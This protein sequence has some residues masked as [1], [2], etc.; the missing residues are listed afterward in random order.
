MSSILA[1]D[2]GTTGSTALVIGQDGS[3]L[4]RGYREF[5][6]HFPQPGWVE[7]D[8]EEIFRVSVEAM[9]DAV[10]GSGERPVG[11]GITNQRETVVLWDRRTLAPVAPAIVWQDRRTTDRCREIREAG[12][13]PMLRERT[14]LVAD[15]YFSATKLEWL[16]RDPGL[17]KRAAKGELAAGTV[18]SWL[19]AKLTGGSSHVTDHTNA[20]RTLLYDLRSRDWAPELLEQ[21]GV[22][23]EVLPAIVRS[24]GVVGETDPR[25]LGWSLP[26]AGLAGDQQAALFGQG[27]VSP[28]L[29]KNTYGTG[30]FLLVFAGDRV[31]VPTQGLLA[32]AACGPAGEPGYAV[33][34]S[35]F[36]AG[37]AVQWLRDGL[38]LIEQ[39]SETEALARGVPDTGGVYFVPAFVGMGTPHWEP[40]ARGTITGL[41][42][43][44]SRAQLVRAALEAM[45]YS[46]AD[47][48]Q[49]M[50]STSGLKVPALRVDGGAAANDWLM[51]FQADILGIPVERPDLVETTALGAA[52]LAG[53]ALGVWRSTEELLQGRKF[54]RFE[55]RMG[56]KDREAGLAGWK[57]AVSATLAWARA[58]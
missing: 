9:G 1:L 44:T 49:A 51:Q 16:L 53:L 47:L 8:A 39:A 26:I 7:H 10:A 43:G 32:T 50:A 55:P 22:P 2:Q 4:G 19:V 52:G 31:P 33:E 12:L 37:A 15:P 48:L 57:K 46:S 36:V 38:G 56:P 6:Q 35:V 42:R 25:H 20:S 54:T 17:R 14:G 41:T 27:C 40:E 29:A 18:D 28:G 24:S 58:R 23:A 45:A 3:V 21:F 30:A 5:T 34:G 11:L 13:E